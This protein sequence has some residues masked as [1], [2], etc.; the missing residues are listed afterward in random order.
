[1]AEEKVKKLVEGRRKGVENC[2]A[3][4]LRPGIYAF[5]KVVESQ[6]EG[7]KVYLP[8]RLLCREIY[9]IRSEAGNKRRRKIRSETGELC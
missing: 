7:K 8:L 4:P 5:R 1:V 3:A 2:V 9:F 6:P